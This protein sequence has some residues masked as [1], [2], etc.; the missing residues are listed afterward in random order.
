MVAYNAPPVASPAAEPFVRRALFKLFGADWSSHFVHT[1]SSRDT[2]IFGFSKVIKKIVDK[3]K[4]NNRFPAR[5][6]L[7]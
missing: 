4:T 7:M 3:A 1:D 2:N 5:F 6:Y